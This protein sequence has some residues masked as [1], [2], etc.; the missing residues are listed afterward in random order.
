MNN[1]KKYS[2][3]ITSVAALAA[4][5]LALTTVPAQASRNSTLKVGN[6]LPLTGGLAGYGVGIDLAAQLGIKDLNAAAK[7]AR[8]A[9]KCVWVGTQ[10]DR[11]SSA[12][13]V[14]AATL[15]VTSLGAQVILGGGMNS[16][17]T[18]AV[19]KSV[20]IP[21][22]IPL[23]AVTSSSPEITTL[24]DHDTVFRV[25]PSDTLQGKALA[26]A[27]GKAFGKSAKVSVGFKTDAFGVGL[28]AVFEREWT[29]A[30]GTIVNSVGW[31][32][33]GTSFTTQAQK[34][35][36]GSPDGWLIID[37]SD[38]FSKVVAPLA[39]T[40]TWK[41]TQTFMTEDFNDASAIATVEKVVPNALE[42]VRGTSAASTGA[43][44]AAWKVKFAAANPS[45]KPTFADSTGYDAAVIACLANIANTGRHANTYEKALRAV[46]DTSAPKFTWQNL[47]GAV[48]ALAAHGHIDFIGP[49]G[50]AAFD[51]NG[52]TG[53]GAF[54]VYKIVGAK[55]VI[56]PADQL[57][58]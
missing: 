49:W 21:K 36:S 58:F 12:G 29:K 5:T 13:G 37:N 40:G 48:K 55:P 19:A 30:G 46:T 2:I 9:A 6:V 51:A 23:I 56:N 39:A 32:P 50:E 34:L 11:T 43:N 20:T 47:T 54:D 44:L 22:N 31:D 45:D 42:G 14:E 17:T 8:I 53:A 18:I 24:N 10:D 27:M 28:D 52:D 41:A 16:A 7:A 1:R 15:L 38:T 4:S 33:A 25:Y 3:L 35:A 26:V 57:K